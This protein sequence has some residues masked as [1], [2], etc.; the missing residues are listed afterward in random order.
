MFS[1]SIFMVS[2]YFY[3]LELILAYGD[4]FSDT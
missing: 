3:H 4:Y 1:S 2:M